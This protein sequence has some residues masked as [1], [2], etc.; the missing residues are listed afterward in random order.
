[1]DTCGFIVFNDLFV[2]YLRLNRLKILL[3]IS[4][5]DGIRK[6]HNTPKTRIN[7]RGYSLTTRVSTA[8]EDTLVDVLRWSMVSTLELGLSV[9]VGATLFVVPIVWELV[10]PA[11]T[12]AATFG[13]PPVR[14]L[15]G[16][17]L[18]LALSVK[19]KSSSNK[20]EDRPDSNLNNVYVLCLY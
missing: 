5:G 17:L 6:P 9:T 3:A 20:R 2:Y 10:F 18:Q 16:P 19:T 4:L 8:S 15:S 12:F 7:Q 11:C 1:M 14:R 13:P